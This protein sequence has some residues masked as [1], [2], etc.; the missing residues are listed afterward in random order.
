MQQETS[1]RNAVM[2]IDEVAQYQAGR[3]ISSNEAI[4]RILSFPI[5]ERS[6]AV[7]HLAVH[8][9][10]GQRVYFTASNVQQR[11]LNPPATTLTA[12]FHL[13]QNDAFAKTLLYSDVPT[14]Y[15]WNASR[16]VFERRKRA[17]AN[18]VLNQLGMPSPTRSAA[19]SFDVE[20]RREQNYNIMDLSSYV[21]SN[22]PKLTLEQKGIYDKIMQTINSG[23]GKIFFLDAPG[24][25][26]DFRQTLPV[27][28]RSTPA[29]EINASLKRSAL[30]QHVKTLKLIKNMRVQ[31][32][33]DRSAEIFSN[34]LLDI[35]NGKVPV[36][37]TSG[38]ISLPHNFCNLV[39][40][41]GE[42]VERV[43]P[44]IQT[45]FKNPNWLSE[46]AILAAKN[47]DVYQLNNVIQSR[48]QNETVTY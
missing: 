23:N 15:T 4:W 3:Y 42:L 19:A 24:G 1:D 16:K 20:L 41:K 11:A 26:G 45:N 8:L 13:C 39:T 10:N 30:W 12:F 18:K 14:Y 48:I 9:E 29:D 2:H 21:S 38:K 28:P 46:R 36:D 7:I 17:I 43:F 33:N 25:T 31:L 47:K 5:H 32:Q 40:S 34:Q 44:D 6:P 37:L 35:G 27:I 22:I